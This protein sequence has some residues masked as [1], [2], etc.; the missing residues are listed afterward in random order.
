MDGLHLD[1]LTSIA[2]KL[3]M[4]NG[5]LSL[6]LAN[7][8]FYDAVRYVTVKLQP[9]DPV[10]SSKL[11]KMCAYFCKTSHLNAFLFE[12]EGLAGNFDMQRL[13]LALESIQRSLQHLVLRSYGET[14]CIQSFPDLHLLKS[15]TLD[16]CNVMLQLKENFNS[17]PSIQSMTFRN[18]HFEEESLNGIVRLSS[19]R[20]LDLSGSMFEAIPSAIT[21]LALLEVLILDGCDRLVA[22]SDEMG[23]M[24]SLLRLSCK[25]CVSLIGLGGGVRNLTMLNDVCFDDCTM[26]ETISEVFL[27]PNLQ[28]LS[29]KGC[30]S[31]LYFPQEVEALRSLQVLELEGCGLLELPE[32]IREWKCLETLN[33]EWC[34]IK[35]L[36]SGISGLVSLKALRL[37]SSFTSLPEEISSL[38]SLQFLDVERCFYMADLPAGLSSLSALRDIRIP[39]RSN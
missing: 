16:S 5:L 18:C 13:H 21:K 11:L 4:T 36:P 28:K 10:S 37:G 30:E 19:L 14:V 15:L 27:L 3:S 35:S 8:A 20:V 31:I 25:D 33:L 29:L 9:N 23:R 38:V 2:Q 32:G 17:L 39:A 24:S 12:D 22:L 1:L 6:R 7:K 34:S 26:L